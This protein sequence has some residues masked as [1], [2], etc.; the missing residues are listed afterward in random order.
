MD[1]PK[2]TSVA[3]RLD[4]FEASP[5]RIA[6]SLALSA[7]DVADGIA[8]IE[9]TYHRP[10][11][12]GVCVADGFGVKVTVERG[13]LQ[14]HDGIG[15]HRRARRYDR[16]THGLRRVVIVEPKGFVTFE[17][18][19]WCK[20]LGIGVL[21]L[22]ANGTP[23]LASTPRVTD[24]ARLRRVQALAPYPSTRAQ[25]CLCLCFAGWR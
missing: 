25:G 9:A 18:L 17:A 2:A 3:D 8:A 1:I 12:G 19:R 11:N 10:D 16:A 4:R 7:E 20:A 24:D 5:P 22:G 23:T 21:V 6:A 13:A 15:S 14:V